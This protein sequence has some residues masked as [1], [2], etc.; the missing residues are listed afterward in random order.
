MKKAMTMEQLVELLDGDRE[1][2]RQLVAEG[3]VEESEQGFAAEEVE[4]VLVASTLVRELEVNWAGVEIILQ[5]R[6]DLVATRRRMLL[7]LQGSE[8]ATRP[9]P[10]G[11]SGN[12]PTNLDDIVDTEDE[13][14]GA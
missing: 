1:I 9:A 3:I 12:A 8:R 10:G 2:L 13:T 4:R 7:L 14:P 11:T 5:L 6:D